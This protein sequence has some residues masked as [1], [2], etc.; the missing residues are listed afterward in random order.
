MNLPKIGIAV[1]WL[2]CL[3]AFLAESDSTLGQIGR[4]VFWVLVV[5]HAIECAAFYRLLK[6][7]PGSLGQHLAGTFVF[8]M[9]HVKDV[10]LAIERDAP[11]SG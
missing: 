3:A 1:I 11:A 2:A 5:V 10:Q 7:A 9:F 4:I 8:G 6:R